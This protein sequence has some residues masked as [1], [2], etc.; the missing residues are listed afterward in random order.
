MRL[1]LSRHIVAIGSLLLFLLTSQVGVQGY[2]WCLGD[3][4]HAALE[5]IAGT[6]C[7]PWG[8]AP[9]QPGH[10]DEFPNI[11]A[12]QE[13][14][15]SCF[16]IPASFEATTRITR[17]HSDLSVPLQRP[18]AVAV[19]VIPSFVRIP[20]PNLCPSPPPRITQTLLFQRTVVLLT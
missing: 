4:G 19:S 16:D 8:K 6:P 13:N 20:V 12:Q 17:D 5:S 14:C 11:A 9:N 18:V 3:E 10:G 15:G 7:A 1:K 2:F